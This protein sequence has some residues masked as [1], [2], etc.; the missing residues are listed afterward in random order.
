MRLAV[1]RFAL[2]LLGAA[3]AAAC[4]S[5]SE[6]NPANIPAGAIIYVIAPQLLSDEYIDTTAGQ[7]LALT[8]LSSQP[9]LGYN[10]LGF[11]P[12]TP[13][14]TTGTFVFGRAGLNVGVVER[15]NHGVTDTV[16]G[17][18]IDP[19]SPGTHGSYMVESSGKLTLNW[20]DGVRNRYFAPSAVIRLYGDT[21]ESRVDL[22]AKADSIRDQWHVY[23]T[24]SPSCP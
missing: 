11:S 2:P 1:R 6:P 12:T 21:V 4:V 19:Q 23:W 8:W 10:C 5:P 14:D 7:N 15:R 24:L 9:Y 18:F 3:L 22:R 20:A 13:T 16:P 17:Y